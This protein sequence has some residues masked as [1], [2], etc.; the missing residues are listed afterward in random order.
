MLCYRDRWWCKFFTECAKGEGCSRA[1]T[2]EVMASA[3][4]WWGDDSP[5]I[6]MRADQPP[7]FE[8]AAKEA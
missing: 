7:C 1:L 3:I 4:R 5:P 8:Q 2:S 6:D